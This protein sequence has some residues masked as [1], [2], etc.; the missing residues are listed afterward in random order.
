MS[1][2]QVLPPRRRGRVLAL[3]AILCLPLAAAPAA[4]AQEKTFQGSTSVVVIE[5][6]VQVLDGD[7]NPMRGLTADD[8][9]VLDGRK[10]RDIVG[11]D[12]IDR[13]A[14]A[15][16]P[17]RQQEVPPAAR[18]H[19]LFLFD[20]SFSE[21]S[22]VLKARQAARQV[23]DHLHPTDLTAVATFTVLRGAE[24]VIGFTTDR[25]RTALAVD[26]LGAPQLIDRSA[27]PLGL[28]LA[29]AL[30]P[31]SHGA[32]ASAGSGG[33][34]GEGR[35]AARFEQDVIEYLKDLSAGTERNN[36]QAQEQRIQGLVTS[37]SSLAALMRSVDGRK[38]VVYLS[39][40]FDAGTLTG[41]GAT[42]QDA[43]RAVESGQ[44]WSVDSE[45]MFGS[46]RLQ[47]QLESMLEE[48]RRA[49]CTVE[50][51]DIGGLR[52]ADQA[53]AA[54]NGQ[55]GLFAMARGTGGDLYR[56]FNDLGEAMD[57]MLAR[58]SVTYV[59]AIQPDNLAPNGDYHKLRVRLKSGA[60]GA[61]V[62][63]RPG[64]FAPRPAGQ[65][66]AA[67]RRLEVASQVLSGR[68]G[69][70]IGVSAL[71][72]PTPVPGQ[73]PAVS[74]FL[75]IDGPALLG[76]A[77]SGQVAAEIY[78]Y[79]LDATGGVADYFSQTLGL[80]LAQVGDKLRRGG[81]RFLGQLDLDPGHYDLRVLVRNSATGA[82]GIATEPVEVP[83]FSSG[84][85]AVLPPLVPELDFDRWLMVRQ[86]P[87]PDDRQV[88]YPFT[89]AQ[90]QMF[91]P[92]ARPVVPPGRPLQVGVFAYNAGADDL[93]VNAQLLNSKGD[94]VLGKQL[95][96]YQRLAAEQ[97]SDPTR[98][99][100]GLE[101][102]GVPEG[103]YTLL[104]G[105]SAAGGG[106]RQLASIPVH[107]APGG[108]SAGVA[109]AG[110]PATPEEP[111]VER[112]KDAARQPALEESYRQ[113]LA[114]LSAD[115]RQEALAALVNME[116]A[117]AGRTE[118]VLLKTLERAELGVD[119]R[120][121][122][123]EP[124]ALTPVILLHMD[125]YQ[126]HRDADRRLLTRLSRSMV[127]ELAELYVESGGTP[128]SVAANVFA[129]LG[130]SLQQAG[131]TSSA[132]SL[133]ERALELDKDNSGALLSLA[134]Y[135]EKVG[136]Y[137]RAVPY[138]RHLVEAHPEDAEGW[139][140]L[141]I[142]LDRVGHGKEALEWLRRAQGEEAPVWI[143]SLAHQELAA[144]WLRDGD[145]AAVEKVLRQGLELWPG[146][147][148]LRLQLA[149]ALDH[150]GQSRAAAAVLDQLQP[151]PPGSGESPRYL[152]NRWPLHALESGHLDLVDTASSRLPVLARVIGTLAKTDT[153]R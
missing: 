88:P 9:E 55:E 68:R 79:A 11:F 18:R 37:M 109:V 90:G 29:G 31:A 152:Y 33:A 125:A 123:Q 42:N 93:T 139:L 15:A 150:D 23:L 70:A 147:Q 89:L 146:D 43:N 153:A 28:M 95:P 133:F 143:R 124:D 32:E 117:E 85:L 47:N 65:Q 19:F 115:R 20:L 137:D 58:T 8:F 35:G 76:D 78:A 30:E 101:A 105:V 149:D 21:P 39:E 104:L 71:A 48:F 144:I 62:V 108:G 99:L 57:R 120:L 46:G 75:E 112:S 136:L 134:C 80:D 114:E 38:Y 5:V 82:S 73:R 138:L 118:D 17:A 111:P 77:A 54:A 6:P 113:V 94:V 36:R 13:E 50:A 135:Y 64:Y 116:I 14:S 34:T 119:R 16:A 100:T 97:G 2:R 26:S 128:T 67:E 25:A 4:R 27:D 98:L 40:G 142:N 131:L 122:A 61:R 69:G 106:R 151:S 41:E 132:N 56:N 141:G 63:Y 51:V 52:A 129:S 102:P 83:D 130:G 96:I 44:L 107:V 87:G 24:L 121:A 110:L 148:R 12:V 7:G 53:A 72:V 126:R 1:D 103:D 91:V 59:L 10:S 145:L 81:V 60:K 92:V 22:A 140:R 49:D 45:A 86:T 3:C 74:V 127:R 84:E 66:S